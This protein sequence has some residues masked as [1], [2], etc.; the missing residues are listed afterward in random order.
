MYQEGIVGIE[1][2]EVRGVGKVALQLVKCHLCFCCPLHLFS[3]RAG[4][5]EESFFFL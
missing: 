1:V 5:R 4:S 2:T 3:S